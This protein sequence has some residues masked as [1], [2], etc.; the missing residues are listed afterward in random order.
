MNPFAGHNTPARHRP[1]VERIMGLFGFGT[2][3]SA[4]TEAPA[5]AIR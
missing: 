3:R 2:Q 1:M 4:H 5:Q